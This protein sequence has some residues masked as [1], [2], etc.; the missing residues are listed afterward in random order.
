MLLEDPNKKGHQ[1]DTST[2]TFEVTEFHLHPDFSMDVLNADIALIRVP[3]P[4]KYNNFI[5]PLPLVT[6]EFG[7]DHFVGQTAITLG[8]GYTSDDDPE[9]STILNWITLDVVANSVC[10]KYY[11]DAVL[12]SMLCARDDELTQSTCTGDSGGALVVRDPH[13]ERL[14]QIG[15]TSFVARDKCTWGIPMGFAR[16]RSFLPFISRVTGLEL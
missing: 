11:G 13:T 16:V 12:D 6:S 7:Y 3:F 5:Q 1:N 10:K 2:L 14:M 4:L 9:P 15:I 8:F